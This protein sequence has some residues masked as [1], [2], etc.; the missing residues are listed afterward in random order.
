MPIFG[1]QIDVSQ[2][3][4]GKKNGD[5]L[6]FGTPRTATGTKRGFE[7]EFQGGTLAPT[8]EERP[9]SAQITRRMAL[10]QL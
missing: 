7:A 2:N 1:S 9:D 10:A 6:L 8:C 5:F 4:I 3:H